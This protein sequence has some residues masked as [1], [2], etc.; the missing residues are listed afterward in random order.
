MRKSCLLYTS[1]IDLEEAKKRN[2]EVTITRNCNTEAVADYAI[3]LMLSVMRHIS[4]VDKNL[5]AGTW[6]KETGINSVSYT[7]LREH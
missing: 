7:H 6:Q 1:N 2:I 3:G 4:T 5:K